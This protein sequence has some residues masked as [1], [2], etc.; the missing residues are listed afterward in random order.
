M[1]GSKALWLALGLCGT[2]VLPGC[3]RADDREM[4][5]VDFRIGMPVSELLPDGAD[6]A[7]LKGKAEAGLLTIGTPHRLRV[8]VGTEV[9]ELTPGG[10]NSVTHIQTGKR[11]RHGVD[12]SFTDAISSDSGETLMS[13]REAIALG[14]RWCAM[15]AK[16]LGAKPKFATLRSS[17]MP[18]ATGQVSPMC[19]IETD[20]LAFGLKLSGPKDAEIADDPEAKRFRVV[21][22]YLNRF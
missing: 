17:P 3:G 15:A 6:H 5:T 8:A 20:R 10:R 14:E 19:E 21:L 7:L 22:S 2:V 9:I 13:R 1:T 12:W 16:G 11:D 4:V 18:P